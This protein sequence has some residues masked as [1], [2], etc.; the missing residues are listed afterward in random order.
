MKDATETSM[1]EKS[2]MEASVQALRNY[3]AIFTH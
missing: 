3:N 2:L 1:E